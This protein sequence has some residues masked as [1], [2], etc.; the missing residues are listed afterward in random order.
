MKMTALFITAM[1]M[2][3]ACSTPATDNA[4]QNEVNNNET[5]MAENN[6]PTEQEAP[7]TAKQQ[8]EIYVVMETSLGDVT[9]A[10]D[11]A[12]APLTVA[13]FLSYVDDDFY[14]GTIFHR[15]I[16]NFMIQGGGFT[17]EGVQKPTK[18]PI[19]LESA[20]GLKNEVGT[21]AMA[22]TNAPNSATCQFFINV[23]NNTFLDYTPSNP[24]YAVFGRVTAGMEVVNQ[25]RQVPTG[26]FSN[27]MG[28]WP[29]ETVLIKRIYRL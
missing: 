5:L 4:G 10:L 7:A 19:I 13:N 1:A 24:G 27:G 3:A 18:D 15:V 28:D 26:R 29:T 12:K 8:D 20:N 17:P 14:S 23:V 9:I 21:I 2:M 6:Q 25:I 16:A 22:R 11:R